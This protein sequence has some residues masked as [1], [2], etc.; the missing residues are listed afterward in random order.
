LKKKIVYLLV[1]LVIL[2][3][4][5]YALH[6]LFE[7]NPVGGDF[8]I[9]WNAGKAIFLEGKNPYSSEVTLRIQMGI[10]GHPAA[11]QQDQEAFAYPPYSLIVLLPTFWMPYPW[12]ESF[13][14]AVNLLLIVTIVLVIFPLAPKWLGFSFLLFYPVFLALIVGN[15]VTQI[16]ILILLVYH[17][18]FKRQ[19]SHT[20]VLVGLGVA[21]AWCT[22]KFQF[23]WLFLIFIALECVRQRRWS[24]IIS[25][26][27]SML[28][29]LSLS[30]IF[31]PS[32][33][34]DWLARLAIYSG[35]IK[36]QTTTYGLMR[37]ILPEIPTL[38]IS[39]VGVALI[40][41]ITIVGFMRNWKTQEN[42]MDIF[43][44]TGFVIYLVHPPAVPYEQISLF[45]PLL[46][47]VATYPKNNSGVVKIIYI[48]F[49]P[50]TWLTFWL[51]ATV[52][53]EYQRLPLGFFA[54]FL[55]GY[56]LFDRGILR[57]SK[58]NLKPSMEQVR[59]GG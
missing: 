25:F 55:L 37:L 29:F 45:L 10:Y 16:G 42:S 40:I 24:L 32:W 8:F 51:G 53:T 9:F 44:W 59:F 39:L 23:S 18:L 35:Y 27:T 4:F 1:F 26:F 21:L 47:W 2:A 30:W 20:W 41:F 38:V 31:V 52:K 46:F 15:F 7:K 33:L 12:G 22:A 57:R 43:L 48:A 34:E 19:T 11:P 3:S 58:S 50:L 54:L 49:I 13:W 14:L 6:L 56:F 28:V 36:F 5:A 17:L